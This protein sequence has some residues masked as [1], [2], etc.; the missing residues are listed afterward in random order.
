ME[1]KGEAS[2]HPVTVVSAKPVEDVQ[3]LA[4]QGS[5]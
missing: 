1:V 2:H 3:T 4:C 5:S